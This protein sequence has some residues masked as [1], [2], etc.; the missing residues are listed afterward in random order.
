MSQKPAYHSYT[1]AQQHRLGS[2]LDLLDGFSD[3]IEYERLSAGISFARS[4][5]IAPYPEAL[6]DLYASF[7]L[8]AEEEGAW[9]RTSDDGHLIEAIADIHRII[10]E[11]ESAGSRD[12]DTRSKEE[13]AFRND[14]SHRDEPDEEVDA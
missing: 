7:Y 4:G 5:A 6:I 3:G 1:P 13:Y 8:A 10:D 11:A 2:V 9:S 12:E 14:P